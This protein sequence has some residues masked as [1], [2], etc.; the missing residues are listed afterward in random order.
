MKKIILCLIILFS[1][2]TIQ[3]YR[4]QERSIKE[5]TDEIKKS[6][7][8]APL[9]VELG[10]LYKKEKK[11]DDALK[12]YQKAAELDKKNAEAYYGLSDVYRRQQKYD[13]ALDHALI[14]SELKPIRAHYKSQL[15]LITYKQEKY[16]E[17]EKYFNEAI[18]LSTKKNGFY[19]SM[20][21]FIYMK[22]ERYKEA[23][24]MFKKQADLKAWDKSLNVNIARAYYKMG[25]KKQGDYYK[26]LSG[27]EWGKYKEKMDELHGDS[28]PK[29]S[30]KRSEGWSYY[31]KQDYDQAV[32]VFNNDLKDDPDNL[33][34]YMGL[35]YT[36]KKMNKTSQALAQ[37]N[38]AL[39]KDE[40]YAKAYVGRAMIYLA[41]KKYKQAAADLEFAVMADP[42]DAFAAG[43]LGRAYVNLDRYEE[44]LPQLKKAL[45]KNP[46]DV[47]IIKN[48]ARSYQKM[49][50]YKNARIWY[51]KALTQ[52]KDKKDKKYIKGSIAFVTYM[53]AGELEKEGK[54]K[55]A[56]Q[57]Y[58]DVI[59]TDPNSKWA[60]Y[61]KQRLR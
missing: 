59:I 14:A 26:E 32:V 19:Y 27:D 48:L 38:K 20:L 18:S 6:P 3:A 9:Y 5:V 47:F 55:E 39:K 43:S 53:Y 12:N 13:Q 54:E 44:A 57:M 41:Q 33:D 61:S 4:M 7:E 10:D 49:K 29:K 56:K 31:K 17:A 34:C 60:G 46:D 37:F 28:G 8:K 58:K 24:D 50:D 11:F 42:N 35:G 23:V 25:D 30:F 36:Y 51:K 1:L 15:G 52:A 45:E 40:S 21:G 2:S 16:K 22:Q